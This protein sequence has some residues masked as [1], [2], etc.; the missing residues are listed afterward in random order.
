MD[1]VLVPTTTHWLAFLV[2]SI[3][4][5]QVP[6]PSLLFTIGRALTVGRRDALLSVA[7]NGIGIMVQVVLIAVGLY[8]LGYIAFTR[9]G[10]RLFRDFLPSLS[11]LANLKENLLYHLGRRTERPRF[12]RF[13]YGEKME[14]WALVWGLIVMAG[15]GIMLWAKVAFGNLLP[16]WWLDIATAIHFYEAL[17]ATLAI[18][19]WHFYSVIFD[20]D[21]YPLNT[22]FLTGVSVKK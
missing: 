13:T 6:G 22:A 14:Y 3:L 1:T 8:H 9:E 20:P 12:G 19:V 4:F 17:L 21:V 18:V 2:A 10:R 16:R 5:I 7:G 15:T 11:D